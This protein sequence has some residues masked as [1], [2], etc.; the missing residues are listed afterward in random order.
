MV[1]V[2]IFGATQV[3]IDFKVTYFIGDTS[4][5]Y[6]Y[7]QLNDK[8]FNTG[9]STVT[10]VDNSSLDFS[11]TEVQKEIISFDDNLE[12]CTGCEQNWHMPNTLKS[13]Y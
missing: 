11:S 6:D 13:W 4:K 3:E 5:V 2:A 10:Y 8:Y 1:A 7:F 12:A 9:T